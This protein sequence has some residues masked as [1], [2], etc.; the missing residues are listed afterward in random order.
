MV[1]FFRYQFSALSRKKLAVLLALS[2]CVG[3]LLG[4]YFACSADAV[5]IS[6]MR[7][8]SN[9]G[10]SI[11]ALLSVLLLPYL[12]TAFAVYLSQLWLLVPLAFLKAISFSYVGTFLFRASGAGGWLLRDLYLFSDCFSALILCWLWIRCCRCSSR[13]AYLACLAAGS[14]LV[15]VALFDHHYISPLLFQ[16]LS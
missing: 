10:V 2:W 12:F 3:I 16:L 7:T 4:M 5:S 8:V 15:L 6:Q 13:G 11:V 1:C 9:P 14:M